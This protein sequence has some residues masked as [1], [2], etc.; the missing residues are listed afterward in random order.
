MFER[1]IYVIGG[2][3]LGAVFQNDIPIF[4]DM[5]HRKIRSHL[6]ALVE[7]VTP[8]SPHLPTVEGVEIKA[9]DGQ[10]PDVQVEVSKRPGRK[11]RESKKIKLKDLEF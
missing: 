5:D 8:G 7:A 9:R 4:K 10:L 11:K 3:F 1:V 6:V 2:M